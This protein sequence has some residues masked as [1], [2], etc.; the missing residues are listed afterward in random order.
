[1][2]SASLLRRSYAAKRLEVC[3]KSILFWSCLVLSCRL[4]VRILLNVFA[5]SLTHTQRPQ[6]ELVRRLSTLARWHA[7]HVVHFKWKAFEE[8]L[9]FQVL[10]EAA[11]HAHPVRRNVSRG[12]RRSA[13]QAKQRLL[14]LRDRFC[15]RVRASELVHIVNQ[16]SR[17]RLPTRAKINYSPRSLPLPRRPPC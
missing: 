2:F 3:S 7:Q 11:F 13:P 8:R 10:E 15:R 1:M 4:W 12:H 14:V 16:L 9:V 6:H 5:R 17:I